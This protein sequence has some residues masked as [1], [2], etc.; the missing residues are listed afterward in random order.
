[1]EL[2][3]EA[4]PPR[5]DLYEVPSDELITLVAEMKE[6]GTVPYVV[7]GGTGFIKLGDDLS[8]DGGRL[9]AYRTDNDEGM[10]KAELALVL[11]GGKTN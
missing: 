1:M 3:P 9:Y 11:N 2:H 7:P 10:L 8:R 6:A 5:A 4:D